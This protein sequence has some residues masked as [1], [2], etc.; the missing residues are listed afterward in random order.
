M[1]PAARLQAV[2]EVLQSIEDGIRQDGAPADVLFSGYCRSRRY[3][4]SKDRRAISSLVY[5]VLRRRGYHIWRVEKARLDLSGRSLLLS[6][7]ASE[8]EDALTLFGDDAAHSP[9]AL[10]PSERAS[11]AAFPNDIQDIQNAPVSATQEVPPFLL[12]PLQSRFGADFDKAVAALN[13]VAPL[14]IRSNPIRPAKNLISQIREISEDIVK[15]E[16][17]PIGY[18]SVAKGKISGSAS[19]AAGSIEI[20]DEAAQVACYLVDAEP[21]MSVVDLC[22]GA[23]GKALL[24]SALM[25]NRGQLFAFDVS[26]DRLK[27]LAPRLKRAGCRNIQSSLL[28]DAGEGRERKLSGFSGKVDRVI[29]DAPCSGTGTWRRNPDQRWRLSDKK[30]DAYAGLQSRLLKEASPLVKPGGRLIYMTCSLLPIE[31]EDVVARFMADASDEWRL[32]NYRAIWKDVLPG[33]APETASSTPEC[34]QFVPHMHQTDGF[35]IAIMEK[36]PLS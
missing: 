14:D 9:P 12:D 16:Y 13:G 29:V 26:A 15:T 32:L 27:G 35:F 34:L 2:I 19:Y 7:L 21:G 3:I 20:Q 25:Q 23:G 31:N 33:K 17:S 1:R 30:I 6:H 10:S 24:V 18:R 8:D 22:A 28:P 5:A 36:S 11:L 4:G